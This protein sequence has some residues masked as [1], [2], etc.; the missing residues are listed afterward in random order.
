MY[1]ARQKSTGDDYERALPSDGEGGLRS[2]RSL[3]GGQGSNGSGAS[4]WTADGGFPPPTPTPIEVVGW[5]L[6]GRGVILAAIVLGA[7]AAIAFVAYSKPRYTSFTDLLILPANLNLAPNDLYTPNLQSDSQILEVESKMRMM[8]SGNVLRRLAN[9]LDLKDVSELVDGSAALDLPKLFGFGGRTGDP[10]LAAVA[11][12]SERI[13]VGRQERSYMITASVWCRTAE[14]SARIANGLADAF[15]EELAQTEADGAG[16]AARDLSKRLNAL[17]DAVSEADT[18]VET[19]RRLHGLQQAA[20]GQ[21]VNAQSMERMNNR[22]MD[23]RGRLAEATSRYKELLGSSANLASGSAALQSPTL[24]SL[25]GEV[26]AARKQVDALSMTYGDRHPVLVTARSELR[27]LTAAIEAEIDR[28]RRSAKMDVD[29]AR[30][31]L[32][33]LS[34]ETMS[35]RGSV[36]GDNDAQIKLRELER[37]ANAKATLYQSY[38]TRAGETAE[39]QRIDATDV[40]VISQAMPPQRRGWPPRIEIAVPVGAIAGGVLGAFLAASWGYLVTRRH[41]WRVA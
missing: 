34:M 37:N 19:F 10:T 11:A 6:R 15:K 41:L 8:T 35:L 26:V 40:R 31:T 27:T 13:K 23:A 12:L 25:R 22:S 36:S 20:G 38:L 28:L 24:T 16:R 21:L 33:A 9:N 14:L 3:I 5:V 7:A 32:A 17:R 4:I 2:Q 18:E 29:E 39:R 30:S 1:G